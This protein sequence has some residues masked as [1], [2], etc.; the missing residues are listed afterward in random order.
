M[1]IANHGTVIITQF[2]ISMAMNTYTEEDM[3]NRAPTSYD[4]DPFFLSPSP[5]SLLLP[6]PAH[7]GHG[8]A[9]ARAAHEPLA[10]S[11]GEAIAE[12]LLLEVKSLISCIFH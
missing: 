12:H 11:V 10:H 9:A 7:P 6:P 4:P 8:D 2:G 5:D 3:R 1:L